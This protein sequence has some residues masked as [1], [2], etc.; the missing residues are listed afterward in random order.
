MP[1]TQLVRSCCNDQVS[2]FNELAEQFSILNSLIDIDEVL[3]QV[4]ELNN[5]LKHCS[6]KMSKIAACT[7]FF[8]QLAGQEN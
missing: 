7:K 8:A 4:R 1:S 6:N 3:E 2:K 5:I